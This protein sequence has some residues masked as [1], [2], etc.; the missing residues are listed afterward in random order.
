MLAIRVSKGSYRRASSQSSRKMVLFRA[1][2]SVKTRCEVRP[3]NP[4]ILPFVQMD[5]GTLSRPCL[6][7][8]I[9]L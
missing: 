8:F 7:K 6:E 9:Y 4:P 5:F 2:E 3:F 1:R